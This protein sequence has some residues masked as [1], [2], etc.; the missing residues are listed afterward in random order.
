MRIIVI[1]GFHKGHVIDLPNPAPTITLVKPKTITVCD[2]DEPDIQNHDFAASQITYQC[3]FKSIDGRSLSIL[4]K[5]IRWRFLTQASIMSEGINLGENTRCSISV[6]MI[7]A[8]GNSVY[9]LHQN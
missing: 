5:E 6:A 7:T 8:L 2:C 3:A 9:D 1:D 4:K